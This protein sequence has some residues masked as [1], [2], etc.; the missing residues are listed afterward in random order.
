[1]NERLRKT[2]TNYVDSNTESGQNLKPNY[3]FSVGDRLGQ[4]SGI[5]TILVGRVHLPNVLIDS[6]TK[7]NQ[8]TWEWL[9]SQK[10]Q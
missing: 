1:M 9:K 2:N 5:V 3:V 4:R 8:G 10:I 6:G 7:C